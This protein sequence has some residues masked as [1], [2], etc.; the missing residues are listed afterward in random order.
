MPG[1]FLSFFTET[2]TGIRA[3]SLRDA[4]KEEQKLYEEES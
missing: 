2:D 3:I 1:S 4:S